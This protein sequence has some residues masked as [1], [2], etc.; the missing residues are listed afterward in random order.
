[1]ILTILNYNNGKVYQINNL[2][3]YILNCSEALENYLIKNNYPVKYC[4][5]MVSENS[6]II[7]ID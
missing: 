2:P 7:Y 3:E 6:E 5:Y 4:D 1:M